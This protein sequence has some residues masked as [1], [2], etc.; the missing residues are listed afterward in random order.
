MEF[1][2]PGT[3]EPVTDMTGGGP[4][5]LE[6]GQW[7]DDT[8]LALCM[9]QSLKECGGFDAHDMQVR[10]WDWYEDGYM[11]STGYCFDIGSTTVAALHRF[12]QK[13][14]EPF[15]GT[16][17]E[18]TAGNGSLMRLAPIPIWFHDNELELSHWAAQS[19][20]LTHS[21]PECLDAC[22]VFA[23]MLAAAIHGADR[24]V[25]NALGKPYESEE[26]TGR[27]YVRDC[28]ESAL[29]AF[30]TTS[31]F[32]ACILAAVNLGN[33]ADTTAAVAGQIAGAFYGLKGIPGHWQSRVYFGAEIQNLALHLFYK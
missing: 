26:G 10:F 18:R 12:K 28:L 21:H 2:P 20:R 27:G 25:L 3:F 23:E 30:R 4:F 22:R 9:G 1:S 32:E 13:P 31:T 19:S 16:E 11:S 15:A 8:S 5:R 14:W 33:D 24:S 17:D 29:W 6:P 7:T